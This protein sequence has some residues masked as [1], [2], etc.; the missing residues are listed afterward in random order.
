MHRFDPYYRF[1]LPLLG[2]TE[3]TGS[4]D[5]VRRTDRVDH[6]RLDADKE[7]DATLPSFL[8][9][10]PKR[11]HPQ[12][13]LPYGGP[14]LEHVLDATTSRPNLRKL[15][16][17][18]LPVLEGVG[19]MNKAGWVHQAQAKTDLRLVVDACYGYQTKQ[20]LVRWAAR[21]AHRLWAP[22]PAPDRGLRRA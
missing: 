21:L 19:R 6:C 22:R 12:L 20:P 5:V 8:V 11:R 10:H 17:A 14:T 1:T 15:I 3:V 4:V 9:R 2:A 13:I 18:F 7:A 16:R